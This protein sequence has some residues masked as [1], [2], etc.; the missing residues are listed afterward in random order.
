MTIVGILKQVEIQSTKAVYKI[1]DHTG[2]ITAILWLDNDS[3][4][5]ATLPT[6]Q[7]GNYVQVF[8]SIR[9]QDG[10][11]V[12]MILRMFPVDDCNIITTHLLE[13]VHTRLAAEKMSQT[14]V[15]NA[16]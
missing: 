6:V 3:D 13:V 9:M 14:T 10:E 4:S 1:E 11:K 12:V 8:G 2:D 15:S 7:E 5:E 16:L